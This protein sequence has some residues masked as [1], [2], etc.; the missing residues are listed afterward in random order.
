LPELGLWSLVISP[1]TTSSRF[2]G[3]LLLGFKYVSASALTQR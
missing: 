1:L 2:K 3:L